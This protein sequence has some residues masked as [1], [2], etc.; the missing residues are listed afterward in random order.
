MS[1]PVATTPHSGQG[2]GGS[3]FQLGAAGF[4]FRNI[5]GGRGHGLALRHQVVAAE[6]GPDI[7]LVTQATQFADVLEQ[8]DFHLTFLC[9]GSC[10]PRL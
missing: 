4:E 3:S 8:N 7:D 5:A 1:A 6:T 9:S 2:S 10:L